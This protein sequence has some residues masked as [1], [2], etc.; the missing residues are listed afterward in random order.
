MNSEFSMDLG[1]GAV[2]NRAITKPGYP[3]PMFEHRLIY[4]IAFAIYHSYDK[5]Y[6]LTQI[7]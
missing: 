4:F 5:I 2:P 7:L 3:T 6:H 1:G